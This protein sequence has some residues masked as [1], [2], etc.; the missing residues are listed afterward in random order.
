M[1]IKRQLY[2][3]PVLSSE[4]RGLRIQVSPGRDYALVYECKDQQGGSAQ[5]QITFHRVRAYRFRAE[6]HCTGWHVEGA[7]DVLAHV[8]ESEWS[9]SIRRET[10]QGWA[11]EWVLNHYMIY[12]DSVGSFEVLAES[13]EAMEPWDTSSVSSES[14]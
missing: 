14:A 3:L 2:E 8:E 13:W 11:D 6:V 10:A 7:Y 4:F 5:G 9:A 1:A 12:L